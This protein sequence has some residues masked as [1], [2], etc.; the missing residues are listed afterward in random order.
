MIPFFKKIPLDKSKDNLNKNCENVHAQ[1]NTHCCESLLKVYF[2]KT[3][4]IK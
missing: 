1:L 2:L 3:S 4:F